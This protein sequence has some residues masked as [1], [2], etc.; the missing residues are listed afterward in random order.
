M[1][2]N[3]HIYLTEKQVEKI[4]RGKEIVILRDEKE[5]ILGLKLRTK[6]R[7]VLQIESQI[8]K[9]KARLSRIK[10]KDVI[11]KAEVLG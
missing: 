5:L 10:V 1:K 3:G 9:L 7:Q 6:K 2:S 8:A 11:E 4:R